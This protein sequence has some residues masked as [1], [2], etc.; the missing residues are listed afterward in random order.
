M[1][2]EPGSPCEDAQASSLYLII[3]LII[4]RMS[5]LILQV[6]GFQKVNKVT[7]LQ[8]VVD[9]YELDY[10]PEIYQ[11]HVTVTTAEFK[12]GIDSP[13]GPRGNDRNARGKT[14]SS[15]LALSFSCN[16]IKTALK[17]LI[18]KTNCPNLN[19]HSLLRNH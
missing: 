14:P 9:L 11:T 13:S 15:K 18:K 4:S 7:V 12:E 16:Q 1:I 6:S 17:I 2:T 8:Y 10:K 5:Y 3:A 19:S